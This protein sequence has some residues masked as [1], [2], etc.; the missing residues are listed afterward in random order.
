MKHLDD[1]KKLSLK[2][3]FDFLKIDSNETLDDF[4]ARITDMRLDLLNYGI[5]YPEQDVMK[6]FIFGAGP[7]LA[8]VQTAFRDRTL[9][10]PTLGKPGWNQA[11]CL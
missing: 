1:N 8:A 5:Q 7:Q 2:N 9:F 6:I 10:H 3:Q 4:L 11:Q